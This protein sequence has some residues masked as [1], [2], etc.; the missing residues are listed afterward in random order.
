MFSRSLFTLTLKT[1][2]GVQSTYAVDVRQLGDMDDGEV[3]ARL[4]RDHRLLSLSILPAH[5]SVPGGYIEVEAGSF[6]MKRCHFV[7]NDGTTI[8]M[9]PHPATAEGK[10]ARLHRRNP[11]LSR[12]IGLTATAMVLLGLCVTVPQLIETLSRIPPVTE[13]FGVFDAPIWLSREANVAIGVAAVIGSIE[14][15][16]RLRTSWLDELAS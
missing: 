3:R 13:A 2:D 9:A 1:A 15:A 4:Y 16:L 7:E 8:Q 10:R 12:V 5:F 14:R 11:T 6:G